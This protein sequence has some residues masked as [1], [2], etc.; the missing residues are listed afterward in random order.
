MLAV[1]KDRPLPNLIM[2]TGIALLALPFVLEEFRAGGLADPAYAFPMITLGMM[3]IGV[4]VVIASRKSAAK[5]GREGAAGLEYHPRGN[6]MLAQQGA[7]LL[8]CV[9]AICLYS[10]LQLAG[11]IDNDNYGSKGSGRVTFMAANATMAIA[12]GALLWKGY[13][14]GGMI[15]CACSGL[16]LA[17]AVLVQTVSPSTLVGLFYY[18]SP[19]WL[20]YSLYRGWKH[21]K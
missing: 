21:L 2:M 9:A 18:L 12:A 11:G 4:G 15:A 8:F 3:G 5:A 16:V 13:R 10:L 6:K 14:A 19:A 7:I 17:N 1:A 20:L